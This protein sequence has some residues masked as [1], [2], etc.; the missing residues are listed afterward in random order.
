MVGCVQE[1]D[2]DHLLG[3]LNIL[4]SS[5]WIVHLVPTFF[6]YLQLLQSLGDTSAAAAKEFDHLASASEVRSSALAMQIASAQ[7][8]ALEVNK[9]RKIADLALKVLHWHGFSSSQ[10]FCD[11]DIPYMQGE[12]ERRLETEGELSS[13]KE[14]MK[15]YGLQVT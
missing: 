13:T 9:E 1:V 8:A 11:Y 15:R 3:A 5:F 7:R 4:H 10:I 6:M 12:V 14:L 2:A